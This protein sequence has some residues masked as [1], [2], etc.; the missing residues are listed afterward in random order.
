MQIE[1]TGFHTK[2]RLHNKRYA[3]HSAKTASTSKKTFQKLH[4]TT[5]DYCNIA[6]N[7]G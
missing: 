2:V 3:Y 4:F 6:L 5:T 1:N 7:Q